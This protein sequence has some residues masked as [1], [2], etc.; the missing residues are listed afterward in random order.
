MAL[1]SQG[2]TFEVLAAD[3]TTW[4]SACI[5]D[6]SGLGSGQAAMLDATTL[7]DTAK[8]KS[9][10]LPDEGSCSI[11]VFYDPA[12]LA[13][14]RMLELRALQATGS[15][16]VTLTDPGN[17]EWSFDGFITAAPLEGLSIDS[18]VTMTYTIEIDGAIVR[19]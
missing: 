5:K 15:F 18:L 10:G 19:S 1:Q 9:M 2:T 17:E 14:I 8:R 16:K 13:H 11:T 6:L 7:C 4:L 3:G 12:N